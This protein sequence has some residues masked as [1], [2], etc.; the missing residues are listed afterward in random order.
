MFFFHHGRGQGGAKFIMI[1]CLSKSLVYEVW[2]MKTLHDVLFFMVYPESCDP[3][4]DK[5]I[6]SS[7]HCINYVHPQTNVHENASR[8]AIMASRT[9]SINMSLIT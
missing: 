5:C 8:N 1:A 6:D 9:L 3:L 7:S 2:S 4:M